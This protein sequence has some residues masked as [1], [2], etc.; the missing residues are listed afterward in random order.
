MR[1]AIVER[2]IWQVE[3]YQA[4]LDGN[5]VGVIFDTQEEAIAE[6]KRIAGM[7]GRSFT[8]GAVFTSLRGDIGPALAALGVEP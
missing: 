5:A 7:I 2:L 6:G 1:G 8:I 3:G 4:T